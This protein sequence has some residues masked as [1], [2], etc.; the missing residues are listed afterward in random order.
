MIFCIFALGCWGLISLS[1]VIMAFAKCQNKASVPQ[2]K[3]VLL[4]C[5]IFL[6]CFYFPHKNIFVSSEDIQVE[7]HSYDS[8]IVS[9]TELLPQ[10]NREVFNACNQVYVIRSVW[11]TCISKDYQPRATAYIYCFSGPFS[12]RAKNS[13]A[14]RK[15]NANTVKKH[16]ILH[17]TLYSPDLYALLQNVR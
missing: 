6:L 17:Y 10:N 7:I 8:S 1:I 12:D 11:M 2:L 4:F 9:T 16:G 5:I 14:V 15:D 13:I 3:F